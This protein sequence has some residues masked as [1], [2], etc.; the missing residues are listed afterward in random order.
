MRLVW[1][2]VGSGAVA[3]GTAGLVVPLM[4]TTP[5]LLVAAWAFARSSPRLHRWLVSHPRFGPAIRDWQHH[6]AIS[7]RAKALAMVAIAA[8]L[9]TSVALGVGAVVLAVQLVVLLCVTVFILSR[10][11][12]PSVRPDHRIIRP[13][14]GKRQK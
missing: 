11:D 8:T 6:R 10:P 2:S 3:L 7:R 9:A 12:P 5:F 13:A 14:S 1:V 4:P